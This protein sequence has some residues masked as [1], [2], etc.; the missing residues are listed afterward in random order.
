MS[1]ARATKIAEGFSQRL[2]K[3]MY[4]VSTTD[5]IVNRDYQGEINGVG[6]LLNIYNVDRI[7]E[8]DY[9]KNNNGN[10]D[11]LYEN[12]SKL[13]IEKKKMFYW[14]EYTI[15]DWLS[16]IKDVHSTV[17]TQKASERAKNMDVYTL[18]FYTDVAAGNRVGTDNTDGTVA[19]DASGNVTG[20]SSN[21][22]AAMVG[23]GFKA[24]GHTS[25]YRVKTYTNSTTIVIEDDLDDITSA[26]TGGVIGAGATYTVEAETATT[27]TTSNLLA[28]IAA[29]KLKLN[30]AERDGKSAV[31]DDGR[32][33]IVPPEFEDVLV[34]ASG[35]ALHVPDVYQE[36]VKAGFITML[37]GFM[38][39]KSNHLV[40]DNTNGFHMIA[41]H[42]NWLTFAEKLLSADIEEEI[43][44]DFGTAYKDLMVYGGKVT[45]K[46]RHFAAELYAKFTI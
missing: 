12:N 21:F 46:R 26:Y 6:S 32:F 28:K 36:L 30:T 34:Q 1:S 7:T 44:G 42:S 43:K 24:A 29:T 41:G 25:W 4:D 14:A 16:Y 9:V 35:V 8:K 10:P 23:R 39:F 2:L 19:I 17:V 40:G 33:L 22:T 18:G 45:D 38:V 11:G 37:Q 20:S 27:I 13:T 31:P 3:E 5:K 15:D